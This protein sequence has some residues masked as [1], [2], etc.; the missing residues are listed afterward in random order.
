MV[1][2]GVGDLLLV[3]DLPPDPE[4]LGVALLQQ[5]AVA[6]PPADA[7]EGFHEPGA[8]HWIVAR[9]RLVGDRREPSPGLREVAALLPVAPHREAEPDRGVRVGGRDRP[10]HRRPDVVVVALDDAQPAALVRPGQLRRGALDE[11]EEERLVAALDLGLL[12][13]LGEV[14]GGELVD[15]VELAEAADAFDL[16]GLDEALVGQRHDPVEHVAA[17]L[18]GRPADRLGRLDVEAAGERGQPPQ[19]PP[20]ALAQQVVAPG[21][22]AAQR[23]LALGQVARSRGQHAELLLEAAQDRVGRQELRPGRRQL[24]RERHP[25]EPGAD[26][27][28]G[29]GVVVRDLEVGPDGDAPA[30]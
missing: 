3:P 23:L 17:D 21:D 20:L 1:V 30:R 14:L 4:R 12:A 22:R 26:R 19:E 18:V 24:D 5:A 27:G 10:V 9:P 15:R 2:Q 8:G 25:V 28:D 11:G 16:L 13:A 29:R 7:A 6:H